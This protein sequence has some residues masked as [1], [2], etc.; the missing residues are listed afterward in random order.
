MTK[1]TLTERMAAV[2][3]WIE[4]HERRFD[5]KWGEAI[6]AINELKDVV[7]GWRQAAWGLAL[8]L[9]AWAMVQ[10]WTTNQR[11]IQAAHAAHE[12]VQQDQ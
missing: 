2:E 5:E 7:K 1:Q 6:G 11:D 8:A 12:T 3:K 4:G 9:L 10:L